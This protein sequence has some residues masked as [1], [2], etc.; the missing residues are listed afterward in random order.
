MKRLFIMIMLAIF[1]L[2]MLAQTSGGMIKRGGTVG[3]DVRKQQSGSKSTTQQHHSTV[4][5]KH[6][7][8]VRGKSE[9][10]YMNNL[11]P[12]DLVPSFDVECSSGYEVTN[13]PSWCTIESKTSDRFTIH[14]SGNISTIPRSDW[15][16][17]KSSWG[18]EIRIYLSQRAYVSSTRSDGYGYYGYTTDIASGVSNARGLSYLTDALKD[19]K[20]VCKIGTITAKGT[21]VVIKGENTYAFTGIPDEMADN[22]KELYRSG[23]VINDV[24]LSDYSSYWIIIYDG[25]KWRGY[26]SEEMKKKLNEFRTS[27]ENILSVSIGYNGQYVVVTDQHWY[28][29]KKEDHEAM[30]N[31][32]N[33]FGH[34]YSAY[35]ALSSIVICCERGCY[36][37][38]ITS[39][40]EDE[41]KKINSIPKAIKYSLFDDFLITDGEKICSCHMYNT[42]CHI[43]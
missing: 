7:L 42:T 23:S 25:N 10:I 37:K 32:R 38:G 15:F 35:C 11:S 22:I 13:L 6:Y 30:L 28:A 16:S 2:Q 26:I 29:S 24:A 1:S 19:W 33:K 34:I 27:G 36:Y 40:L 4:K 39:E 14:I 21:G 9:N 5:K 20:Y 18:K 43:Y 3:T 8:R 17:V 31:A 12:I 41:I